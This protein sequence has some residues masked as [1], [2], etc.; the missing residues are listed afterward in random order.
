M[1]AIPGFYEVIANIS[2]DGCDAELAAI[3]V[4]V[5]ETLAQREE[6]RRLC[7]LADTLFWNVVDEVV[8]M[9]HA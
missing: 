2:A 9:G 6:E 8:W 4:V 3:G 7:A 1:I 5:E